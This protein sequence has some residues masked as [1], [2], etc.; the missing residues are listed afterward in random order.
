MDVITSLPAFLFAVVLIWA[1]PGPAMLLV[2]RRAALLGTRSA[3][4]TVLGLGVGLYV[5]ALLAAVGLGAV[6]AASQL[7]YDVLRL[8]GAV[9]LVV[10]GARALREAWQARRS[11]DPDGP[12]P[13]ADPPPPGPPARAGLRRAF[14]E[15][16][17]V[18]LANPKVAV[19]MLAFYPQFVPAG[20]PVVATTAVLALVQVV[21]ETCLYVPVLAGV[22]RAR[23]WLQRRAVRQWLEAVS[24]T[25]LVGLGLRV[26]AAGR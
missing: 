3:T 1:A 6:V 14:A 26:A 19:F 11:V 5:W 21:V 15:G 10:V 17:L 8:V 20:A 2:V 12:D 24:G 7:A 22:A 16:L 18:Q 23:S 9:F 13:P 25:V 4:A